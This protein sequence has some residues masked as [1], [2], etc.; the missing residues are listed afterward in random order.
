MPR[1]VMPP[2]LLPLVIAYNI[3]ASEFGH[4]A[5][6]IAIAREEYSALQIAESLTIFWKSLFNVSDP[7]ARRRPSN[8]QHPL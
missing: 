4:E 5:D 6:A 7:L 8:T 3:V 1:R 2:L